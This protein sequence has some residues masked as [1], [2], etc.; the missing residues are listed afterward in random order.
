MQIALRKGH[1]DVIGPEP[2][3]DPQQH[4]AFRPGDAVL[5]VLDPA[6]QLQIE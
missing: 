5:G 4:V 2:V 1:L 6:T 3:P